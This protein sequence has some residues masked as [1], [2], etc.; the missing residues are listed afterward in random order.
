MTHV[1]L[2]IVVGGLVLAGFLLSPA[3]WHMTAPSFEAGSHLLG[4][5]RVTLFGFCSRLIPTVAAGACLSFFFEIA[6][7]TFVRL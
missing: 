7:D 3:V 2:T 4:S 1:I 6:L 5:E